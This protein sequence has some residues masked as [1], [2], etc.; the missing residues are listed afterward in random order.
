MDLIKEYFRL[1]K[2]PYPIFLL[3]PEVD[4]LEENDTEESK[5]IID[6]LAKIRLIARDSWN[7]THKL[8]N[9]LFEEISNRLNITVEE[10]KFLNPKE[11][12]LLLD[13]GKVNV[14]E[15]INNRKNCFFIHID[16][17]F[18]LSENSTVKFNKDKKEIIRVIL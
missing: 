2:Q 18:V 4:I 8:I 15:K 13:G 14:D 3:T 7:K 5:Y 9:P 12:N 6:K 16:G 11:I 17:R 10:L 1:Y